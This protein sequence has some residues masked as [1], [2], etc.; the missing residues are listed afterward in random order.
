[1]GSPEE[2]LARIRDV[3]PMRYFIETGTYYGA[4]ARWASPLFDRVWTTEFSED[5]YRETVVRNADLKNVTFLFGDSRKLLSDIV[6]DLREGAVFWFDAHYSGNETYGES[7]ECPLLEE[8]AV[9]NRSPHENVLIVDDA[10]HYLAPPQP[11]HP[12]EQ[13]PDITAVLGAINAVPER[14]VVILEDVIVA[15][16]MRVKK[17]VVE[18]C[19]QVALRLRAER[20]AKNGPLAEVPGLTH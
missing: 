3:M 14:Y 13:W 12:P 17:V 9:V 10:R 2:L 6:G 15:A 19:Q 8:L 20:L 16:P 4:T 18:Y 11:F 7:D 1:M 5:V